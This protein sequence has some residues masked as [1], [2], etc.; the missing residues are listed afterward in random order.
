MNNFDRVTPIANAIFATL[1][2]K[3]FDFGMPII[4]VKNVTESRN[5]KKDVFSFVDVNAHALLAALNVIM[6]NQGTQDN[7]LVSALDTAM[8]GLYTPDLT[9]CTALNRFLI[10]QGIVNRRSS[11]HHIMVNGRLESR[12]LWKLMPDIQEMIDA[13]EIKEKIKIR[14]IGENR[15]TGFTK[16]QSEAS[17]KVKLVLRKLD[18]V[19]LLFHAAT[20]EFCEEYYDTI[21]ELPYNEKKAKSLEIDAL[22]DTFN[23]KG[24]EVFQLTHRCDTRGR[25][26]ALGGFISTQGSKLMKSSIQFA[27]SVEPVDERAIATY[28]GRERGCKGTDDEA[29]ALGMKAYVKPESLVE[30][31]TLSDPTRAIIRLDGTSNG[32]QWMSAFTNNIKGMELTN[33]TG[34]KPSKDLYTFVMEMFGLDSRDQAKKLVMPWSYGASEQSLARST[35]IPLK[36]I[37]P[38][39]TELD[40]ILP[41]SKY[42]HYVERKAKQAVR[43]G[44]AEFMWELPD[45]FIVVHDYKTCDTINV[46]NFSARIGEEK[47]DERKMVGALAPNIIHSIDSYHARLIIDQCDFPVIAIHDSFGCHSAHVDEMRQI[48]M[49]TF[50]QILKEDVL[51]TIFDQL[52]FGRKW[53]PVDPKL[54]TNPYMFM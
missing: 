2:K 33:L 21:E 53:E 42:L 7:W 52:G 10:E 8:Q 5:Q 26:Y 48:I 47:V 44:A 15:I 32:I 14:E 6:V 34:I 37:Q 17:S 41:I 43:K 18:S 40:A 11:P 23:D 9:E 29:F 50:Q 4:K 46:G 25:I 19:P 3:D 30:V 16:G 38:M 51:N 39:L 27:E 12:K 28:L 20:E 54:I 13:V 36:E 24:D 35:G 45:G 31:A 49:E 1:N 22:L